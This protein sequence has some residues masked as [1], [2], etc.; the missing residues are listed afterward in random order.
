VERGARLAVILF[1]G[2]MAAAA[3]AAL[4]NGEYVAAGVAVALWLAL[5]AMFW[6]LRDRFR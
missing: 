1:G 6:S 5:A 2:A 3:L 4:I